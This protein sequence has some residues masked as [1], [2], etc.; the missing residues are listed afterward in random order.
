M[1]RP[2][3]NYHSNFS[4]FVLNLQSSSCNHSSKS[5]PSIHAFFL[6]RYLQGRLQTYVKHLGLTDFQI[7]NIRFSHQESQ[8]KP[9]LLTAL[10]YVF[11]LNNAYL[12]SARDFDGSA[13]QNRPNLSALKISFSC[14]VANVIDKVVSSQGAVISLVTFF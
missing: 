5:V 13:S 10:C 4:S 3:I 11:H 14:Y 8:T 7:A 2:I 12:G 1:C 9:S 6:D